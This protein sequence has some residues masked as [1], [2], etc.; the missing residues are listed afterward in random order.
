MSLR[1]KFALGLG[2]LLAVIVVL[3][4]AALF[5]L[6]PERLKEA[7]LSRARAS[8][9]YAIEA[10]PARIHLG[11]S[12]IG[13]RVEDL[14]AVAPDSS[15][16]IR[17]A[18]TDL[19]VKLLPLLGRRVELRQV[20]LHHPELELRPAV[21]AMSAPRGPGTAPPPGSP[22]FAFLAVERWSVDQGAYV[23]TGPLGT[24]TLN[25]V[26]LT[27]GFSWSAETGAAGTARGTVGSGLWSGASGAFGL[28]GFRARAD[29]DLNAAGDSLD[30]PAITVESGDVAARL[31]GSFTRVGA[32]WPGAVEGRVEPVRWDAIRSILPEEDLAALAGVDLDGS[33]ALP[34]L[35]IEH[36]EAGENR[37][38]G[39]LVFSEVSLKAPSAPLGLTG[40]G[41]TVDF[42]PG[43]V[44]LEKAKGRLGDHGITVSARLEGTPPS[45]VEASVA[46]RID[47]ATLAGLLPAAV[48]L[49]LAAGTVDLDLS[50]AGPFPVARTRLPELTGTVDLAG[51][52]GTYRALPIREGRGRLRFAG[53]AVE[54]RDFGAAVGRSDFAVDGTLADI[55]RP[56]LHFTWNSERLD[57]NEL[58]P[59]A[60]ASADTG[61]TAPLVGVPGTGTVRVGSLR[62]RKTEL[63]AVTAKVTVGL[64]GVRA[65]DIAAELYGGAATG[66]LALAPVED[67]TTWRYEGRV[68]LKQVQ[69]GSVLTDWTPMGKRVEGTATAVM[70]FSGR[71][72]P[73]ADPLRALDLSATTDMGQGAILNVPA[74]RS[75]A[76][77]LNL[78]E[79]AGE[80][81]PFRSLAAAFAVKDGRLI[82]DTLRVAQTGL[83]WAIGGTVGLD[84]TLALSGI[85]LADPARIDLPSEFQLLA[86]YVAQADGRIPVDFKLTGGAASPTVSVDWDALARRA[87]EKARTDEREKIENELEKSITDPK[88]LDKLK[89]LLGGKK[90]NR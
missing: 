13:V 50:A 67:G 68:S 40:A 51:F 46:T 9:G 30:L 4:I 72:G 16:R 34:G 66:R 52:A 49:T 1:K 59:E 44:A 58:F 29:F 25:A 53:H 33:F 47:G 31:S 54:V 24:L 69:V 35:R 7:A 10:G 5:V 90:G 45:R 32:E 80:R 39:R 37:V 85:L 18:S 55:A 71:E 56:D 21:P 78:K 89:K 42:A 81:W 79:A 64:D 48:P 77:Y 19:Y 61:G 74:L 26:D 87:T 60:A 83:G 57:L 38:S 20:V 70:T 75:I 63:R 62:F 27:G 3:A 23:Q 6:R 2:T 88:T 11:L 28:P 15:Q 8:T 76:A 73:G 22:A 82:L 84:G 17:I 12:G 41:G 86:P 36:T 14:R 65:E 43:V